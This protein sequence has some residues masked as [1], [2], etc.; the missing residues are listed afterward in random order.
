MSTRVVAHH[1]FQ[2]EFDAKKPITL[3][4]VIA[5]IEWVNPHVWIYLD[6]KGADK[7]AVTW[8]VQA[9]A[10]AVLSVRGWQKDSLVPGTFVTI[11][12]FLAKNGSLTANGRDVTLPDGKKLCANIPCRCCPTVY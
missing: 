1:A 3:T 6:V 5:R 11:D 10:P 2:A 12:G 9:G 7:S 8:A 4:G